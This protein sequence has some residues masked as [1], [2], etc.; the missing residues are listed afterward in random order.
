MPF[1][2][3]LNVGIQ[4]GNKSVLEGNLEGYFVALLFFRRRFWV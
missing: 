1:L 3:L 4:K 2:H